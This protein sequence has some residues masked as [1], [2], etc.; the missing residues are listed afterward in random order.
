MIQYP[1]KY[2]LILLSLITVVL[3]SCKDDKDTDTTTPIVNTSN[4]N[5]LLVI[6]D[7]MGLD[8]CPGYTEGSIKPNMPNLQR[9]IDNGVTYDNVWSYPLCAPT[10]AS[11]LTGKY[12]YNTGVLNVTTHNNISESETSIQSYLNDKT[13]N[14]YAH[15]IF[16]KWHLSSDP[17]SATNMGVGTYAGLLKGSLSDYNEWAFTENGTTTDYKGYATTKFTD[18]A[19]DWIGDQT[20]PWFCW[21]A[22]TTP[23][24]PFHL[25][26]A[27]M[28]SQGNLPDDNASISQN[29]RPYFMAMIESID[30]ELGRIMDSLPQSVLDNT[31]ILFIGD[32]GTARKVIQSPYSQGKGSLYQG[33][34][35][36]PM[37]ISGKNVSRMNERDNSLIATTDLFATIAEIAGIDLP[38]YEDSYSFNSTLTSA[39][40]GSRQY[41]YTEQNTTAFP[42]GY[43][44][45]NEKY[46]LIQFD[47]NTREM[48]NLEVDGYENNNLFN[49]GLSSEE[50]DALN[51]LKTEVAQIR[52]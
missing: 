43:T 45:R 50:T 52:Q 44:I 3:F 12:G 24:T 9:M 1:M 16:G 11:I 51:L 29:P 22:Y 35:N 49:G 8:A 31:I 21:L 19:I 37:I 26:P 20:K 42:D 15:A 13:S 34:V 27:V 23:H 33:G 41:V 7:D 40:S 18:L 4:V 39:N 17:S 36:V 47:A 6:A 28:H 38:N 30:Y 32:N 5:I 14:R 25:P 48:Y 46:K 10:R 2:S